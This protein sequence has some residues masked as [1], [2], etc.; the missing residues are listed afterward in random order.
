MAGR[1]GGKVA[2]ITGA[3]MGIG[4]EMARVFSAEG[5]RVVIADVADGKG[6]AVAAETGALYVHTD[7]SRA[8]EV[9]ALFRRTEQ[10]CGGLDVLVNNAIH[11]PGDTTIAQ[12]DEAAWDATIA[13][14]LKGPFLCTRRAIPLLQARGGGSIVTMSSVNALY[15]VSETAYT[16]AKGG[17]I[18]MMRLVAAEYGE[19]NIRSNLICPGTIATD[20][21]MEYWG[22]RP[23]GFA[24][25]KEMY[26]L[27]RIGQ[28]GDVARLALFLASEESSFVSGAVH[29]IDGGLLSG[30]K[31][32]S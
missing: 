23:E 11:A 20:N 6:C 24:K 27:R 8:P 30:R 10:E 19:W 9:D 7:I 16:A 18:S 29:V 1:L 22:A 4:A 17:L 3:A 12:L 15:G 26:P 13:V 25:L 2:V 14:C 21:C 31:F 32:E 5:A 28:P